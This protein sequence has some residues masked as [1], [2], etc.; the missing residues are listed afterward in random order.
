MKKI[1][2]LITVILVYSC[3]DFNEVVDYSKVE[4]PN[5]SESSI[6]GQP[7]SSKIWLT[8]IERQ[9]A[10][11]LNEVLILAELGSDNYVNTQTY[12]N[13]FM[14][15]L[16]IRITDPDIR[17]TQNQIA[18]LAKM[19]SFGLDKVGPGDPNYSDKTKAEYFFFLGVS[20]MYAGMYFSYLPQETLGVPK[21]SKENLESAIQSFE[22][23]IKLN[24][25]AE[26]HLANSRCNYYLGNKAE[27]IAS[28][29]NALGVDNSFS[30]AV[31][32][33]E[34]NNPDNIL[35]DALYERATFDD[36][37]PLPS[38]DFLDP[39]YSFLTTEKDSPVHFLKA[40]EAYLI[41]AEANL[42]DI[43]SS[44]AQQNLTDLLTLVKTREIRNIDDNVEGRTEND[45]GSRPDKSNITVNGRSGLVLDRHAGKVDIPSVSGTSLSTTEINSLAA[46]DTGLVLIYRTRQEVFISEGI[47]FV[48]MGIKLVID[49]NEILQN[50]NISKGGSGTTPV[51]P[52]FIDSVKDKLDEIT[53]DKVAGTVTTSINVSEIL[54]N[55]KTSEQ[56]LP[57][58]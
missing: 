11:V 10:N 58:H 1:I 34:K 49:E 14:D 27:A 39:K 29:N 38:L 30:R 9:M 2:L 4:N 51:I 20:R 53:Y 36:F 33:D 52:S 57:F 48:D 6:V 15:G 23:A 21:S 31:N 19:A 45:P 16:D 18:R 47:R 50:D 43:K 8:G 56:V 35:E 28:A 41:L 40:E 26:Y 17:D 55:N 22:S 46:D 13:Q 42:A 7:N 25:K 12:F 32:F 37:Q 54:V 5:L 44:S 3:A 24:P